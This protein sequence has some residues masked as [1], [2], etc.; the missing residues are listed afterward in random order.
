MIENGIGRLNFE[1][2]GDEAPSSAVST[3]KF[4]PLSAQKTFTVSPY[5][6]Y[7]NNGGSSS[8]DSDSMSDDDRCVLICD[9]IIYV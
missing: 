7:K 6:T 8:N 1:C 3:F 5:A 4:V 2:L 9:W